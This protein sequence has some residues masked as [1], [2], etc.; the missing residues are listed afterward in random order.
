M[1]YLLQ[2]VGI[3]PRDEGDTKC[4]REVNW[5]RCKGFYSWGEACVIK[6]FLEDNL[7]DIIVREQ[8]KEE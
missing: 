8:G 1:A 6:K 5:Y 3:T 2:H 4:V 7:V